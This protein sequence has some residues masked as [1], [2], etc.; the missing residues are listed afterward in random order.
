VRGAAP[1]GGQQGAGAGGEHA[2]GDEETKGRQQIDD[3]TCIMNKTPT[4][5]SNE[6]EKK[7]KKIKKI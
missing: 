7:E 2:E 3:I 6:K 4:P 5:S 1:D